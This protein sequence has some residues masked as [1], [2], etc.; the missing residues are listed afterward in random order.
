M[1]EGPSQG[2]Q[3][4]MRG[5]EDTALVR[6]G[7]DF[8]IG[9]VLFKGRLS[10]NLSQKGQAPARWLERVPTTIS[11]RIPSGPQWPSSAPPATG[12]SGRPRPGGEATLQEVKVVVAQM[13]PPD[14]G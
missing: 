9:P 11:R 10:P 5:I 14:E 13:D 4:E 8:D 3:G 2:D 12:A 7:F 1:V 6:G